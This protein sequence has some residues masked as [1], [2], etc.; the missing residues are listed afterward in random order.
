MVPSTEQ[1]RA[2]AGDTAACE[3]RMTM[4]APRCFFVLLA[5]SCLLG[6]AASAQQQLPTMVHA[7]LRT[8]YL[9][10]LFIGIDRGIF[11]ADGVEVTYQELESGA[12]SPAAILSGQAHVTSDEILGIAP[13]AKQGKEFMMIYNLMDR[14]TMNLVV[15]NDVL[16]KA[17]FNP[18][19]SAKEKAKVLKGLTI[20]ITRPGAP[21]D[22]YSRYFMIMGGLDPKRDATLVQIG[23]GGALNAA[24]RAGRIDAFML[25]PPFPQ[26]AEKDGVGTII[27]NNTGGEVPELTGMSYIVLFTSKEFAEKNKPAVKA[28][29]R[30]IQDSLKWIRENRA[31]ALKLLGEKWFKNTKPETL[32]L[33]L[34]A[35]LP[36][37]SATG[38]FTTSSFKKFLDV[39]KT[40][41][42]TVEIDLTEGKLWTNEFIKR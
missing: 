6:S 16:Q 36:S 5:V 37:L 33:S 40:V 9:A 2:V 42:E 22:T 18:N 20:G 11:K 12:L 29:A 34:N 28:Y 32:E 24:F 19:A 26:V 4:K 14:M 15:R 10:P 35:L 3:R 27:F 31:E 39:Y 7:G 25:S 30:G 1:A 8:L 13:L 17:G 38:E 23:G 21:T 41:G